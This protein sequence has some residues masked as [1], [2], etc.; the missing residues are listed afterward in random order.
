MLTL[1]VV[2][3]NKNIPWPSDLNINLLIAPTV[4]FTV[5]FLLDSLA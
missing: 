3:G 2:G 4:A 1:A 5:P